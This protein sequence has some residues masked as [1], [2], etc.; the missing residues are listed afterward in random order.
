MAGEG[1][2]IQDIWIN[3][4]IPLEEELLEQL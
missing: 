3:K 1:K 4:S 2:F